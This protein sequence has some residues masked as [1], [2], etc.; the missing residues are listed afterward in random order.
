MNK[1][2][3]VT[4]N[5]VLFFLFATFLTAKSSIEVAE[6]SISYGFP[7]TFLIKHAND[8]EDCGFVSKFNLWNLVLDIQISILIVIV[9]QELASIFKLVLK[10]E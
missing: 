5:T 8:C 7:F 1:F 2:I 9:F 3:A 6:N 4:T 10:K